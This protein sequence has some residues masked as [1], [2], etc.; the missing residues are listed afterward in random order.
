MK[1]AYVNPN[2]TMAMTEAMVAV[3]MRA[4]PSAQIVG[5]TNSDGPPAI[6]GAEDGAAALPGVLARIAE[7]EADGADAVVIGCFDDTGLIEAQ[8][9]T[10]L[11]V[12]GIGQA[13]YV[14]A[15][16]L[17]R[18]FAVMTS[19]AVSIP[20]IEENIAR[21]GYEANC[22]AVLASDLPVLTIDE[23]SEETRVHL[24]TC[25]TDAAAKTKA[26]AIVLGCAGMAPL[27][28][29]LARRTGIVLIDGVAASAHLAQAAVGYLAAAKT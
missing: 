4:L 18:R 3:A 16:V 12:L 21:G 5:F 25:I 14:M 13:S 11:P 7:A 10:A 28:D 26:S 23:G 17:G 8:A 9:A 20:V 29:D 15:G 27:R 1:I 2:A 6:Q 22:A 24:A 19:L